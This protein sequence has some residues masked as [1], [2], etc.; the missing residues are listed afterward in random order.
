MSFVSSFPRARLCSFSFASAFAV[1]LP[2]TL[3][4]TV[5]CPQDSRA[6]ENP[7]AI[8]LDHCI[9]TALSNSPSLRAV[10]ESQRAAVAG[11]DEARAQRWPTLSVGADFNY[12][13][14]VNEFDLPAPISRTIRFGDNESYGL[15]ADLELPLYTGGRLAARER[16]QRDAANASGFDLAADSLRVIQQV[17]ARFY[18]TLGAQA[19][20]D[21][22]SLA[23]QRLRRHLEQ[24]EQQVRAGAASTEGQLQVEAR[25]RGA[26]QRLLNAQEQ[27][28]VRRLQLGRALGF[29]VRE[30]VPAGQLDQSLLSSNEIASGASSVDARP[31]LHAL[32][33][34]QSANQEASRAAE[35][36]LLPSLNAT[37]QL[38]YARPGVRV[39]DNEW[40]DWATVGLRLQW[41]LFDKGGRSARAEQHAATARALS[42]R[43][44]ELQRELTSAL[45]ISRARVK[46]QREQVA[47]AQQ[48]AA[49]ESQRLE[50]V[51]GRYQ[52][53]L[54]TETEFLDAQDD[55]SD[56]EIAVAAQR[57]RLR[58]AEVNL[59]Y[60]VAR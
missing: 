37:A 35:G 41:T 34:R 20:V 12:Q 4:L 18:Q 46:A 27:R 53:G 16:A 8:D 29:P 39:I 24:L 22:A 15:L 60:A 10:G 51:Q 9:Q 7:S 56:A 19:E 5:F 23:V 11:V 25:L 49:L 50:L 47:K 54:G 3:V 44:E 30:V 55:L 43:H 32:S 31:E 33:S 14:E 42:H 28:S 40:M 13:S 6:E 1:A 59:L 26:E 21:A 57:S 36:S 45:E 58:L 38:H 2:L 48:R 17:R 52:Q